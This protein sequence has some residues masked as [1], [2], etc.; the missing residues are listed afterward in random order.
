MQERNQMQHPN[1][2][3]AFDIETSEQAQDDNIIT[4]TVAS[5]VT[6]DGE[7]RAWFSHPTDKTICGMIGQGDQETWSNFSVDG[8]LSPLMSKS[9]AVAMLNY[10]DEKRQ[11][12]YALCAWNGAG[13]DLKMIGHLADNVE[14]AGHLAMNLIDPMYQILSLKGYPVSLKAAQKGLSVAQ[15]KSM[16]GK[17]APEAWK[18][19]EYQKCI[20]YVIGDSQITL[21]IID[22]I[23][24]AQGIRWITKTGK[25]SSVIFTKLKTVEECLLDPDPDTSWMDKPI[26]RRKII[27]WIPNSTKKT[28]QTNSKTT[29]QI[30]INKTGEISG[31]KPVMMVI[32]GPSGSGKSVL[33]DELIRTMPSIQ[34]SIT[35]TTRQP[36]DGEVDGVDYVF[37]NE[38][39]F[40]KKLA[41][42]EFMEWAEVYGHKCGSSKVDVSTR[43]AKGQDVLIIV[44]VQGAQS[45]RKFFSELPEKTKKRFRF[46]DIFI[47]PPSIEELAKRLSSRGKDSPESIEKRIKSAS[48]EMEQSYLYKYNIVNNDMNKAWDRLRSI[49]IAERSLS[50]NYS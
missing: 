14:L 36:R 9:T 38:E 41:A 45:I 16:D 4:I 10:M 48:E 20:T 27:D 12:G 43:L 37:V 40:A 25:P 13:F 1:K 18:N 28:I 15:E 46:A 5:T 44:D 33:C 47:S 32:S 29:E 30:N 31:F 23:I 42:G 22:A 19:G 8:K 24:K 35:V 34:R 17:D 21:K 2:F 26:D 39:T 11:Q 7:E 3:L 50:S 6:S 49:L